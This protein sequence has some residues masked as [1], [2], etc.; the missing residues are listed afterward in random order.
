MIDFHEY[1]LFRS[2]FSNPHSTDALRSAQGLSSHPKNL[3]RAISQIM[4]ATPA[5]EISA[6]FIF[7]PIAKNNHQ[8]QR[9]CGNEK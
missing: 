6:I 5:I 7:S 1:T 8:R 9:G 2:R 4:P 3:D